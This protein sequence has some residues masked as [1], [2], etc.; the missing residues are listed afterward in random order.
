MQSYSRAGDFT[1][2][3]KLKTA[4]IENAIIYGS[5]LIIFIVCLIYIAVSP[6]LDVHL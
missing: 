5:Y 6:D 3:G 4:L 1:I 2:S